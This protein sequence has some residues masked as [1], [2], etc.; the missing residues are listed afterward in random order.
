[1]YDISSA[2]RNSIVNSSQSNPFSIRLM[3]TW[4]P[5]NKLFKKFKIILSAAFLILQALIANSQSDCATVPTSTYYNGDM[6]G[7]ASGTYDDPISIRLYIHRV[8][9]DNGSGGINT[10]N[11]NEQIQWLDDHYNQFNIYFDYCLLDVN[12]SDCFSDLGA[13]TIHYT[14]TSFDDGINLYLFPYQIGPGPGAAEDVGSNNCY[15][16]HHYTSPAHEIGH[17]LG[18]FHTFEDM[19]CPATSTTENAPTLVSS[20]LVPGANCASAGDLICDTPADP[21]GSE[22][23]NNFGGDNCTFVNPSNVLDYLSNPYIDPNNFLPRNIMSYNH[24]CRNTF[25][26]GQNVRIRDMLASDLDFVVSPFSPQ[27][28]VAGTEVWTTP[29]HFNHDLLI[30]GD[31]TISTQ[32]YFAPG[33]G[34]ILEGELE[35]DGAVLDLSPNEY[36]C[37]TGSINSEFWKGIDIKRNSVLRMYDSEIKNAK[38]AL[39]YSV[40]GVSNLLANNVDFANNERSFK[41]INT[42]SGLCRFI[43]C[44]FLVDDEYLGSS[45]FPQVEAINSSGTYLDNCDFSFDQD[46]SDDFTREGVSTYNSQLIITSNSGFENWTKGVNAN[47]NLGTK[48]TLVDNCDFFGN[49]IGLFTEAFY[50]VVAS[51]NEFSVSNSSISTD[52]WGIHG[53]QNKAAD[54]HHNE[55]YSLNPSVNSVGIFLSETFASVLVLL[56]NSFKDLEVGFD[57]QHCGTEAQGLQLLCNTNEENRSFD[58]HTVDGISP[59]HGSVARASGNTFSH[60]DEPTNSD[61]SATGIAY[62]I[63]Y[64]YSNGVPSEFPDYATTNINPFKAAP[65]SCEFS[66]I[67]Q[68][69]YEGEILIDFVDAHDIHGTNIIDIIGEI[70]E[71]STVEDVIKLNAD[72]HILLLERDQNIR[73]AVSFVLVQDTINYDDLRTAIA[74]EPGFVSEVSQAFTYLDQGRDSMFIAKL[75]TIDSRITLSSEEEDDLENLLVL[76]EMLVR[77]YADDRYEGSLTLTEIDTVEFVAN[78]DPGLGKSQARSLLTY[79]YGYDFAA[80]PSPIIVMP[81]VNN[82]PYTTED[83]TVYPNPAVESVNVYVPKELGSVNIA[84]VDMS[85]TIL[86]ENFQI[87]SGGLFTLYTGDLSPGVFLIKMWT[88]SGENRIAKFIK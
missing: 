17:C 87:K 46:L 48:L 49:K 39:T 25:T 10:I 29:K 7:M 54:I 69:P 19:V 31:L 81:Q 61:F 15:A 27:R 44:D 67:I 78:S 36:T 73:N 30:T 9:Q 53:N 75:N 20:V 84:L 26:Y 86:A 82:T 21:R 4:N 64:F 23:P 40:S 12:C 65:V 80:P 45:F 28:E 42:T 5:V 2:Y 50:K 18:L 43:D 57:G 35:I 51:N 88:E 6:N 70:E 8:R 22:C 1:M 32:V 24:S 60:A 77:V 47:L 79:F 38:L 37:S 34:I 58:F 74:L 71:A 11:M 59:Y 16:S 76:N 83:F 41:A 33:F 3:N 63:N 85:G 62:I 13:L 55:L 56:E 72:L 68:D 66:S 14:S 52:G